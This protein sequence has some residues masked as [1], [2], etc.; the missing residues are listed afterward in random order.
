MP[1]KAKTAAA[2]LALSMAVSPSP[3]WARGL[4][5]GPTRVFKIT[6]EYAKH[7]APDV[8]FWAWPLVNIYNRCLYFRQWRDRSSLDRCLSMSR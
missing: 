7:V 3:G 4:L 8:Y 1:T 5:G 6:P 2:A